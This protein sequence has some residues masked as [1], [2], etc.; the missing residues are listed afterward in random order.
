M[1]SDKKLEEK[2]YKILNISRLNRV[3][4]NNRKSEKRSNH[5]VGFTDT[6]SYILNIKNEHLRE[7]W[8]ESFTDKIFNI[9]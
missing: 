5:E 9:V 2:E 6:H 7:I 3:I 1:S 8:K 4:N